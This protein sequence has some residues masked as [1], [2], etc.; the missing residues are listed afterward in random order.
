MNI[1]FSDDFASDFA[2][3]GNVA[4]KESL[5]SGKAGNN[6]A[7]WERVKDAFME[8]NNDDYDRLFFMDDDVFAAQSHINPSR[9]VNHDWKKL[10]MMWK[11][12]NSDYKN[13]LT[14]FTVSGTHDS[15]FFGFCAGK[16][17]PYYL[18]MHLQN[19]P[20]LTSM[21]EAG[22]P[23][24]CFLAS[25]MSVAEMR[26]KVCGA[27]G[28]ISLSSTIAMAASTD[29]NSSCSGTEQDTNRPSAKKK[30]R[31]NNTSSSSSSVGHQTNSDSRA[32]KVAEA[33]RDLANAKMQAEL[34]K[35]KLRYMENEDSRRG[36][37]LLLYEWKEV[38]NGICMLRDQLERKNI[39]SR[40][41]ADLLNDIEGLLIRKD[42]L[43]ESLQ[44][45]KK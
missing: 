42:E 14:R 19:R 12:V 28:R 7:F 34:A 9:I 23:H 41:E 17:E 11:S 6:Q 37:E 3:L 18:R 31:R 36:R 24:E 4:S 13:A 20:D 43:A 39:D 15:N 22:L 16:L 5:D 30:P 1:L 25:E 40:T 21:V 35:N 45:V 29:T 38:Q 10:R 44:F 26:E 33:I 8:P 2:S 32:E 27:Q